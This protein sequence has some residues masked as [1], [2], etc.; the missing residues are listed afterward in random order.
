M[1]FGPI[2]SCFSGERDFSKNLLFVMKHIQTQLESYWIKLNL[3]WDIRFYLHLRKINS[4]LRYQIQWHFIA[5]SLKSSKTPT[6]Y[7]KYSVTYSSPHYLLAVL[8]CI[9]SIHKKAGSIFP[10]ARLKSASGFFNKVSLIS[11]PCPYPSPRSISDNLARL[12]VL[13]LFARTG[14]LNRI[15]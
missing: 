3:Q 1:V 15:F 12:N 7:Y 2:T 6:K 13:I 14:F 9:T 11:I 10:R 8:A 5:F 4:D